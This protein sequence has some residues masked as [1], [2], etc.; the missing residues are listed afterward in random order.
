MAYPAIPNNPFDELGVKTPVVGNNID[1]PFPQSPLNEPPVPDYL[2]PNPPQ[3][4]ASNPSVSTNPF[5]NLGLGAGPMDVSTQ[6]PTESLIN[7]QQT[8]QEQIAATSSP[9]V[10]K[11][12]SERLMT[13]NDLMGSKST[14]PKRQTASPMAMKQETK[15]EGKT[16][17]PTLL[18]QVEDS[19]NGMMGAMSKLIE[20]KTLSE[21][22]VAPY[23]KAMATYVAAADPNAEGSASNEYLANVERTKGEIRDT[24]NEIKNIQSR[25]IDPDRYI[26]EM[27]GAKKLVSTL[28]AAFRAWMTVRGKGNLLGKESMADRIQQAARDDVN[29]QFSELKMEKEDAATKYKL[30]NDELKLHGDEVN[31]KLGMEAK[32]LAAAESQLNAKL[33]QKDLTEGQ[34]LAIQADQQKLK[35][36]VLTNIMQMT[37]RGYQQTTQAAP[38][39]GGVIPLDQLVKYRQDMRSRTLLVPQFDD[40]N[41]LM[42]DKGGLPIVQARIIDSASPEAALK[43]KTLTAA[44]GAAVTAMDQL[45]ALRQEALLIRDKLAPGSV[46]KAEMDAKVKTLMM[47]LKNFYELGALTAPDVDA[48][49]DIMGNP[50]AIFFSDKFEGTLKGFKDSVVTGLGAKI[51]TIAPLTTEEYVRQVYGRGLAPQIINQDYQSGLDMMQR[52]TFSKNMETFSKGSRAKAVK[53]PESQRPS[54]EVIKQQLASGGRK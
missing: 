33:K 54:S 2:N 40:N 25:K 17:N 1:A 12:A 48:M 29:F 41:N 8:P 6:T 34:R 15:V 9:Q 10:Q 16:Y 21:E 50:T 46:L 28:D 52:R 3:P 11:A 49:E 14:Q 38:N 13:N 22:E 24:Y 35:M 44:A 37:G 26:R 19:F 43:V 20:T 27:S 5:S 36:G 23:M 53:P 39:A 4:V 30:L 51:T 47:D 45:N 18:V 31:A 42:V 32:L 7:A